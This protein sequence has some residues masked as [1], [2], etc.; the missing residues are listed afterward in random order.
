MKVNH[1]KYFIYESRKGRCRHAYFFDIISLNKYGD[2]LHSTFNIP[3]KFIQ[4]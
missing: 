4:I 1:N 2:F 3:I